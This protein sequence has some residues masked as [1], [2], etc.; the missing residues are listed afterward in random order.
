MQLQQHYG[1]TILLV[2]VPIINY[3]TPPSE[4]YSNITCGRWTVFA[5]TM[6]KL[7]LIN[8]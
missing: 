6:M 8:T 4:K 1:T 7:E 2:I 5:D 3:L